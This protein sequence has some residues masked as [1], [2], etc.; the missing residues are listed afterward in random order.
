MP[1]ERVYST[2][3][4]T[5]HDSGPAQPPLRVLFVC[6]K[7]EGYGGWYTYTRDLAGGLQRNGHHVSICTATGETGDHDLLPRPI[8]LLTSPWKA[9]GAARRLTRILQMEK[10]DIIHITV[11]PYALLVPFLPR[12]YRARC[13]LTVHGSYGIRPLQSLLTRLLMLRAYRQVG[14]I[15][16]VSEYTKDAVVRVLR[17]QGKRMTAE[18][19]GATAVVIQNG[20]MLPPWHP[21]GDRSKT[22]QI[23]LV[24]GVKPRKGILEALEACAVFARRYGADF[25]FSIVGSCPDGNPYVEK[26]RATIRRLGLG[27]Q[28]IL[29]G[30]IPHT[31]LE[32]LYRASD[33]YLMPSTT[34][35]NTFE[36]YG[37]V[38]IE[39][40]AR[41]IPCIGPATSGAAEAIIEGKTGYRVPVENAE[42]IADKMHAIL[43]EGSIDPADCRAWAEAHDIRGRVRQIEEL[44]AHVQP[45]RYDAVSRSEDAR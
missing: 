31:E 10:P 27:E 45:S 37:I 41:G 44:Y 30:Q 24:G 22:L 39:A 40:N 29:T 23:L 36:G 2:D 34:S 3:M 5:T 28:V 43:Q 21:R 26:V 1:T 38:F 17:E 15:I 32:D 14:R 25:R 35:F 20:I 16:T 8:P 13:V 11:E 6:E 9:Y 18:H 4:T 42:L 33:L 12:E 19:I 7:T